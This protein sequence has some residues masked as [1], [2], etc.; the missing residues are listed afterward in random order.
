VPQQ[1]GVQG[2]QCT[3]VIPVLGGHQN[4]KLKLKIVYL[5]FK[6]LIQDS[7]RV[8]KVYLSKSQINFYACVKLDFFNIKYKLIKLMT[9]HGTIFLIFC[10]S[11]TNNTRR[12]LTCS[13]NICISLFYRYQMV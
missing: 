8:F 9:Y 4:Q 10:N 2:I 12:N 1:L 11:N 3:Q 13:I 7:A 5:K 6:S